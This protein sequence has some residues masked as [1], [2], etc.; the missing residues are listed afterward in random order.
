MHY[1][2][3]ET[4]DY[5]EVVKPVNPMLVPRSYHSHMPSNSS[6]VP[7]NSLSSRL[8]APRETSNKYTT[9]YGSSLK[10][11]EEGMSSEGVVGELLEGTD[12]PQE[13]PTY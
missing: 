1:F 6:D 13:I 3:V 4:V 11:S 7:P 9:E 2:P 12:R 8:S 5:E 10:F